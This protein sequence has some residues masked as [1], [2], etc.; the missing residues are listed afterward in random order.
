MIEFDPDYAPKEGTIIWYFQKG[1]C[2]LVRVEIEQ[3]GQEL[4]SFKKLVKK[5]V[6]AKDKAAFRPCSYACETNQH[7]LWG[8]WPSAAKVSIQSQRMKD[9]K[10]EKAKSRLQKAKTPPF[11]CSNSAEIF[12]QAQKKK[13]KNDQQH[14]GWKAQ[15]NFTL[16]TRRN[17][18]NPSVKKPQTQNNIILIICYNC[19]KKRYYVDKCAKPPKSKN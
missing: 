15:K 19:R 4:D 13:K 5:T 9:S 17:L 8:S 7:C 18:T 10:I 11:Q 6:N 12:K 2:L 16:T 14:W 3:R 1:L